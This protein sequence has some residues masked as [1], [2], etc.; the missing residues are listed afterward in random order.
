[1]AVEFVHDLAGRRRL[2]V[3]IRHGDLVVDAPDVDAV[4]LA[5]RDGVVPELREPL[6]FA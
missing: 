1:M 2:D 4:A 5:L 3:Q 6:G